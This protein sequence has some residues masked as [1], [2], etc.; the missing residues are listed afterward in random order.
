MSNP[1]DVDLLPVTIFTVDDYAEKV[2]GANQYSYSWRLAYGTLLGYSE[3]QT[4]SQL[5][6]ET[7]VLK[8]QDIMKYPL[9]S[10]YTTSNEGEVGQGAPEKDPEDLSPS[11]EKSRNR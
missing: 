2:L 6:F 10:S 8:L 9:Q 3:K 7:Q 1:C 11:G 4:M 5:I